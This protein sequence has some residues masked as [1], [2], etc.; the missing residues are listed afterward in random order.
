MIVKNGRVFHDGAYH[1]EDVRCM[2]GMITEIGPELTGDDEIFD[3]SG[4]I[5]F[6]GFIDCHIHG[7][8]GA[9]FSDGKE[10]A[11]QA[12]LILPRFGV[13]S[14]HPAIAPSTVEAALAGVRSIRAAKGSPGADILGIHIEMMYGNR[15]IAY[16]S[17]GRVNPTPEHTLSMVD[18]DLSDIV[19][20]SASPDHPG[21]YAWFRWLSNQGVV[22]EIGYTECSAR[23]MHEAADNGATLLNHF[24]NGFEAMDHHKNGCVVGGLLEPRLYC[25]I[26]LDGIHVASDFIHMTVLLKGV[27]RIIPCTDCS[28]FLGLPEGTYHYHGKE[29][30]FKDGS[31]RDSNGKLVAGAHSYDSNMRAVKKMGFLTMEELGTIFTENCA[32]FL[33]IQDRG[34]ISIG[35]R[36]GL[37]HHG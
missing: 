3:A 35:R 19:A 12:C 34:K 25:S 1:D 17:E 33:N 10:K 24:Y 11:A 26:T 8:N 6:P 23:Q 14:I 22:G 9:T 18:G 37:C 21:A 36:G 20:I 27:D 5:V 28:E 2:G 7:S 30:T 29:I 15:S 13:T 31:A 32:R 16:Y 4:K